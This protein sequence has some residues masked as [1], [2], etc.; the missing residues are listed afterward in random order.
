MSFP[1]WH[2]NQANIDR[3]NKVLKIIAYEFRYI[4][5]VVSVI[6][7]LNESVLSYASIKSF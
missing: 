6:A 3:T 2:L 5:N 1:T 4:S 7:P